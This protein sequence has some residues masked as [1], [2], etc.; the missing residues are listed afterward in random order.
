MNPQEWLPINSVPRDGTAIEL[1][2]I[3]LGDY[4]ACWGWKTDWFASE[5]PITG[6]TWERKAAGKAY[7]WLVEDWQNYG[8][9]VLVTDRRAFT[10][11][12]PSEQEV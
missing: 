9:T 10:H 1:H 12:R 2:H 7:G 5:D 4:A 6:E 3:Q 8:G 11:W